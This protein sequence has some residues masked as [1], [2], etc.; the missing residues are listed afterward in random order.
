MEIKKANQA[1]KHVFVLMLENRSFD[2]MLGVL[3][4]PATEIETGLPTTLKGLDQTFT[5]SHGGVLFNTE[6]KAGPVMTNDPAH[7]FEDVVQQLCGATAVYPQGGPYPPINN[8]GFVDNFAGSQN[9]SPRA[10]AANLGDVMLGYDTETKLPVLTALAKEFAVCDNWFSSLP[11]PTWPNRFFVHGASS[12]GLEHSPGAGEII[13]WDV[14]SGFRFP[15]GSI[16]DRLKQRFPGKNAFRIYKGTK[17]PLIGSIPCVAALHGIHLGDARSYD[18]FSTDLTP[19]YPFPYTFIEPNYGN[20]LTGGFSGGNSQHPRDDVRSGE[21]LIRK[22]YLAI[23]NSPLWLSS[24]LIITYDEHGGF[25]DHVAPGAVVAPGDG[26]DARFNKSGFAFDQYGVRVP[27]LVISAYTPKSGISH[28]LYDHSSIPATLESLFGMDPLTKRDAQANDLTSLA[29]LAE[30]RTDPPLDLPPLGVPAIAAALVSVSLT[31]EEQEESSDTGNVPG[32]LH[33][34]KKA[35]EERKVRAQAHALAQAAPV[36]FNFLG[37]AESL[38]DPFRESVGTKEGARAYLEQT[39][40][41]FEEDQLPSA[42]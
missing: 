9:V 26:A 21:E 38:L 17:K 28:R 11:G 8:S 39:L 27:A 35:E 30:P 22:T 40:Q 29:A 36:E 10:G 2:H 5:N 19:D 24:L 32:F 41:S 20:F 33:I 14:L 16:F 7:E 23:R 34:V 4:Y 37:R 6:A 15:N 1:I 25:F 42:G 18:N 3:K 31:P 12:A 13:K